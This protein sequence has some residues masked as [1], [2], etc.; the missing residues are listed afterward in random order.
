MVAVNVALF[1]D[2]VVAVNVGCCIGKIMVT[3]N[4][5][6]V[7]EALCVSCVNVDSLQQFSCPLLGGGVGALRLEK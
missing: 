4:G 6:A 5:L 1:S 2:Y 7:S 3:M